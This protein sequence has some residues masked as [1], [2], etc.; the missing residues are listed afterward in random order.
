M[1]ASH[2]RLEPCSAIYRY[3]VLS[4]YHLL[5]Y[6][7]Y[8]FASEADEVATHLKTRHGDIK[9]EHRQNL[10]QDAQQIPN[11]LRNQDE[12]HDLRYPAAAIKPIRHPAPPKPDGLECRHV[13]KIQKHCADEH[14]W[15]NPRGRGRLQ[16]GCHMSAHES[17]WEEGVICQRFFPSRAGSRWFQM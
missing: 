8:E 10:V 4:T 3:V 15:T 13:Q 12:L 9:P 16:P 5:A 6:Q 1:A 17:P 14:Q 11:M 2:S 7:L